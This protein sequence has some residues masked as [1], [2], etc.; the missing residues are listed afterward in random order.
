LISFL[1]QFEQPKLL[2]EAAWSITNIACGESRHINALLDHNVIP[3][4]ATVISQ[5]ALPMIKEQCLWALSNIS[6]EPRACFLLCSDSNYIKLIL[7]QL[8]ISCQIVGYD[9]NGQEKVI[10]HHI[11]AA[12][13]RGIESNPSLSI[14]RHVTFVLGNIIKYEKR[15]LLSFFP[16][17]TALV[18]FYHLFFISTVY[19]VYLS[20][21]FSFTLFFLSFSASC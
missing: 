1:T 7:F 14:M 3:L 6:S 16:C 5:A 9:E 20:V 13:N 21:C 11:T 8:G 4:L 17:L 19:S 10:P 2:L 12:N 18:D 15:F